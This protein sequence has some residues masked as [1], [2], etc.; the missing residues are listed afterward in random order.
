MFDYKLLSDDFNWIWRKIVA[1]ESFALLRYGDGERALMMGKKV[2]AQ[3]GWA[4]PSTVTPLGKAI[5]KAYE[6]CDERVWHGISCPCCDLEAFYWY[7]ERAK[8]DNLTFANIWVNKN[9]VKF[10]ENFS[11]LNCD[12]VLIANHRAKGHKIANLNILKHYEIDDDCVAFYDNHFTALLENIKQ[13]FG[14]KKGLLYIVSAGPLSEPLIV[15]LFKHNP[16][17][18]YIDFGSVIDFYYRDGFTRDYMDE[19]SKYGRR[20]CYMPITIPQ[21]SVVLNLYKRPENLQLQIEAL[22]NQSLKPHEILL[23]QDGTSDGSNIEAP[24]EVLKDIKVFEKS[25]IN[26]GVWGRFRFAMHNTSAQL[27]CVFDDDTIPGKDWLANCYNEF[28]QQEGLYGT[29]GILVLND[30]CDYPNKKDKGFIRIG[31]DGNLSQRVEVD[32]V[33]HSWFF[34]KEWL[35]YLFEAPQQVQDMKYVGED[36]SFSYELQKHGIK[37]FVPPHPKGKNNFYG[38]SP[39]LAYRLGATK[40]TAVSLNNQN[41]KLMN[42]AFLFLKN[43]GWEFVYKRNHELVRDVFY[44]L[45]SNKG[46]VKHYSLLKRCG[47]KLIS[48]F[49]RKRLKA[50]RKVEYRILFCKFVKELVK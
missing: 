23:F 41:I 16:D 30:K 29:I 27:V 19:N 18:T 3:E 47:K 2:N 39:D 7:K 1:R 4:A 26:V 24:K 37:T 46:K 5:N 28:M 11:K 33:G 13:D 20:N 6:F 50:D 12:A 40:N 38:S 9:F 14:S 10:K 22:K 42:E 36:M 17:N 25:P 35:Q 45:L 32:F 34:K 49:Y 8:S 21:I 48:I 15:E 31:W 43:S 44:S